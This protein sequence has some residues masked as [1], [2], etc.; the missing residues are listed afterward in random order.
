MHALAVAA[1]PGRDGP[2]AGS[3]AAIDLLVGAE[4]G[5]VRALRLVR[6]DPDGV[7]VVRP[8]ARLQERGARLGVGAKACPDVLDWEGTGRPDLLLGNAAGQ[9]LLARNLG[10]DGG[11]GP[12]FGPPEP[13]LA[14]GH[15][16]WLMA[17]APGTIQGPSEVK[18]GYINPAAGPWPAPG[19]GGATAIVCGDA[20]GNNT[21]YLR[22]LALPV[23]PGS[24]GSPAVSRGRRLHVLRAGRWEPLV[25]RWRCRPQLVDW[26]DGE[27]VYLQVDESGHLATYRILADGPDAEDGTPRVAPLDVLRHPDGAPV[28]LDADTGGRVGRIKLAVADWDGDG[29]PDLIA[30]TGGNHPPGR[31][32]LRKATV[33]LLRNAGSPGRPVLAP[34]EV[35]PLEAGT[36]ARFGGHSCVPAPCHL[37]RLAGAGGAAVSRDGAPGD[38]PPDL[39]VGSE[40]GR[41]FA[42]RR[43]YAEGRARVLDVAAVPVPDPGPSAA[44]PLH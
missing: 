32:T 15:P 43:A 44:Q 34:P 2:G 21:V 6:R 27:T 19:G 42:F 25:T 28:Q 26:G 37:D 38:G 14:A 18:W 13:F 12:V 29:L 40:N 8:P 23:A 4:D 7:P 36:P 20:L 3:G 1:W 11:G 9:V 41:V 5:Y 31:N 17:G 39:L 24:L 16:L 35:L 10:R 30:G 22:R 33:W